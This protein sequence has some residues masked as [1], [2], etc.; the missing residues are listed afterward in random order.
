MI[1]TDALKSLA[2]RIWADL[3]GDAPDKA[4]ALKALFAELLTVRNVALADHR[5]HVRVHAPHKL[6]TSADELV[7]KIVGRTLQK[8]LQLRVQIHGINTPVADV[9]TIAAMPGHPLQG[10]CKA[11]LDEHRLSLVEKPRKPGP[12]GRGG[13]KCKVV[14]QAP[15][16]SPTPAEVL[17]TNRQRIGKTLSMRDQMLAIDPAWDGNTT[18][19]VSHLHTPTLTMVDNSGGKVST[20]AVERGDGQ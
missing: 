5:R 9:F 18:G 4:D 2:A 16:P 17:E 20:I 11:F 10:E 7:A 15:A 1:R 3:P 8:T 6:R 12:S 19:L 14:V 13:R